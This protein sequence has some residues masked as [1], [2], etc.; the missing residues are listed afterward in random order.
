MKDINQKIILIVE[1]GK[2]REAI[3]RLC[4]V[5]FDNCL[6]YLDSGVKSWKSSGYLTENI[7]SIKPYKFINETSKNSQVIDVREKSELI[8]GKF[9]LSK[10]IPLS[11]IN[12]NEKLDKN[13]TSY[14]YCGGGYRSVIACSILKRDKFKDLVNVESGFSG[15]RKLI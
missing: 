1:D 4:R 12:S 7:R 14:V 3:T 15:I 9:K 2:E 13:S 6:G 11:K 5:G 10:N 8:N